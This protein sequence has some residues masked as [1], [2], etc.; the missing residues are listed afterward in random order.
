MALVY[1][2]HFC[3]CHSQQDET[4]TEGR[5]PWSSSLFIQR[6]LVS[7]CFFF[8]TVSALGI[9]PCSF[10]GQEKEKAQKSP[11]CTALKCHL[12]ACPD[13]KPR[14]GLVRPSA[15]WH[16]CLDYWASWRAIFFSHTMHLTLL[17]CIAVN[18]NANSS[19]DI[20]QE[21]DKQ[22]LKRAG[23]EIF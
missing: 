21:V 3:E 6:L 13:T 5:G 18:I 16:G 23:Y 11:A 8:L 19:C 7:R 15:N 10:D 12:P 2:Q 17:P 1:C 4:G 14:N 22:F 20:E 9:V